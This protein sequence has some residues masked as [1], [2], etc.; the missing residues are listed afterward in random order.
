MN[1]EKLTV[2]ARILLI[3]VLSISFL[4]GTSF[5]QYSKFSNI[6]ELVDKMYRHPVAVSSVIKKIDYNV[7]LIHREMKDIALGKDLSKAQAVVNKLHNDTLAE[8]DLLE[9]RFLGDKSDIKELKQWFIDWKQ[10]RQKVIDYK[11]QGDMKNAARIT[12]TEGVVHINKLNKRIQE[13][14]AFADN[15]LQTFY[16][17]VKTNVSQASQI[18]M[19]IAVVSTIV[20]IVISL[21]IVNSIVKPLARLSD[22]SEQISRGNLTVSIDTSNHNEI[23]QL[24]KQMLVMRDSLKNLLSHIS[25]VVN[26]VS[27]SSHEMERMVEQFSHSTK[28]Q[29]TGLEQVSTA[30]DQMSATVNEVAQ[31][32]QLALNAA[33]Q[34]FSDASEGSEATTQVTS[35]ASELVENTTV[36]S[37]TLNQLE[38]ETKNVES[39]LDMIREISEQT[40]LLA[41]NAAIEAARAGEHGRGFAVVADEVRNLA[42]KTQSSVDDIQ[43]TITK[44]QSESVS[45]VE[46]MSLNFT[47][48]EETSKLAQLTSD[49]LGK[50][51]DS[52]NHIQDMNTHIATASEE[53]SA[54]ATEISSN[55]AEI[56]SNSKDVMLE[57]S[58]IESAARDLNELSSQLEAEISK[59]RIV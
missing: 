29:A 59:F 1:F 45:A 41:L 17:G 3:L 8:F 2:R 54:V 38:E 57:I 37:A 51:I 32:A 22:F 20:F 10:I 36:V 16:G 25:N 14:I 55:V 9:E 52:A 28:N 56:Y 24:G 11:N 58:N 19:I 7:V 18:V 48:S 44:L 5:F 53:Q 46:K 26:S 23:D 6:E 12:Q 4:V 34:T 13:I 42:A 43:K 47:M 21:L 35:Q 49:S 15:K 27:G 50:I 33:T 39:V 40:N 31:N 30:V